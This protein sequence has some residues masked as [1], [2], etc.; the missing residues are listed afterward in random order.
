[1]ANDILYVP[2][3]SGKQATARALGMTMGV[4]LGLAGI[5]IAITR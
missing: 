5:L 2:N 1:M 3:A 4:G